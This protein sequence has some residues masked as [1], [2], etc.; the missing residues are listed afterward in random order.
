MGLHKM[1]KKLWNKLFGPK[2]YLRGV[3]YTL[4]DNVYANHIF[5]IKLTKGP[6]KNALVGF[7]SDP[8]DSINLAVKTELLNKEYGD[9]DFT[10]NDDWCII[11]EQ[12]FNNEFALAIKHY[13]AVRNEIITDEDDRTDYFEEP[14]P[15]RTIRKEGS[16]LSKKRVLSRQKRKTGISRNTS[17]HNKVQPPANGGIDPDITGE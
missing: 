15:Q 13:C 6:Y 10:L 2:I 14:L 11:A 4:E 8:S 16:S 5:T 9:V 7:V 3:H 17:T 1:F 12:I